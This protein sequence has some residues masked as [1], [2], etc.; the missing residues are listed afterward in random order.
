VACKVDSDCASG[1]CNTFKL[2]CTFH[3]YDGHLDG[4]E[5]DV[6]CGGPVCNSC[7]SGQKC[8]S[9]IDCQGGHFCNASKV[10]Q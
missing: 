10:C 8:L 5:T 7:F 2:I 3:C 4:D 9:S 6:D 1:A